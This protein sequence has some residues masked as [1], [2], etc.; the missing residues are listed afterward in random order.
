MLMYS[1]LVEKKLSVFKLT[2]VKRLITGNLGYI[3]IANSEY[4]TTTMHMFFF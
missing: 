3:Y 2:N 1:V 4:D